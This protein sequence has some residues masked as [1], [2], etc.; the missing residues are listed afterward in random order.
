[1]PPIGGKGKGKAKD[2]RGSRSRNT[3][4]S[5]V[6]SGPGAPASSSVPPYLETD[7]NKQYH[8]PDIPFNDVYERLS[9]GANNPNPQ[10]L[11]KLVEQLRSLG[12][13]AEER[14][15]ACDTALRA[16]VSRRQ[17]ALHD[18]REQQRIEREQE[19]HRQRMKEAEED[20]EEI[21][22]AK[23]N[24]L[25]KRKQERESA[26][27]EQEARP[28]AHGAREVAR[29]DK[30]EIKT[31]GEDT[32][33]RGGRSPHTPKIP[34]DSPSPS[35]RAK[36]SPG[37]SSLSEMPQSPDAGPDLE[38]HHSPA[39]S[40]AS[41][42]SPMSEPQPKP[43]PPVVSQAFFPDPL[44]PDPVLY[45][46]RDVE[47]GMTD[48]EKKEIYSVTSFPTKDLSDQIAGIPPD[49]DFSNAKPPNQVNFNTFL[50]YIDPYTRLLTE[51]DIAFLRER[52]DRTTPFIPVPRSKKHYSKTWA[53]EDGNS[54]SDSPKLDPNQP[55]GSAEQVSDDNVTT[56]EV[57]VGP[58]ASRILSLLRF[59]HRN[60]SN[61]TNSLPNGHGS[62]LN[63]SL[64]GGTDFDLPNGFGGEDKSLPP[65]AAVA[66]L[67]NGGGGGAS[68]S[69][70]S[71]S[72]AAASAAPPV[73]LNYLETDERLKLELRH[74]GLLPPDENP[75]YDGH[76]DDDI[77][78]RLRL[79]Q[80]ELRAKMISNG[81]RKARLL[82]IAR[83]RLA[84]Q[85]YKTIHEDLDGQVQQAYL[86]RTRTLGKSKKG[87]HG[88]PRPGGAGGGSHIGG[89]G[90]GGPGG[91][92][93]LGVAAKRDIGDQ[94]R[95]LMDRRRRW[96]ES[97]GPVFEGASGAVPSGE[98]S[99]W[100]TVVMAAYEKAEQEGLEEET[101]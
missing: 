81:A 38:S 87:Q 17:E 10:Y 54:P 93:G 88:K 96:Q 35:K 45:H 21:R 80:R 58:L 19:E 83:E 34:M 5:S 59:E 74:V 1:M 20:E 99:L 25:K 69:K 63:D 50:T 13:Y 95:M 98:M 3:T 24:K 29:Q 46:I 48:D 7:A 101:E 91:V 60:E 8:A 76:Y 37:S 47:P 43:A 100:E 62:D 92:G 65:S 4:P 79:L 18:Q 64:N 14:V 70:P 94:A 84:F 71:S 27:E 68:G 57:S 32:E 97:I 42:D 28:P 40:A 61:E 56:D 30:L 15:N 33:T 49:K 53:E 89:A 90:G 23:L 73:K 72:S 12:K 52:G 67:A 16:L 82:E 2:A 55:R 9:S 44:A 78:E 51:E 22:G 86:K 6:L 77:S 26:Q 41:G 75:D 66:D 85:E 39:K 31:E 11:E 36:L